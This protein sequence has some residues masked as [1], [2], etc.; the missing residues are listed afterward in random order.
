MTSKRSPRSMPRVA[1]T[2][3][4]A[5]T[6]T[7]KHDTKSQRIVRSTLFFRMNN[8]SEDGESEA[9]QEVSKL[10]ESDEDT[11]R[12]VH[13][14]HRPA[15]ELARLKTRLRHRDLDEVGDQRHGRV[16]PQVVPGP[17][18]SDDVAG[19]RIGSVVRARHERR[20]EGDNGDGRHRQ[21]NHG[22][23]TQS[24]GR[25]RVGRSGGGDRR[26]RQVCHG[27]FRPAGRSLP[28]RGTRAH[29]RASSRRPHRYARGGPGPMDRGRPHRPGSQVEMQEIPCRPGPQAGRRL[30]KRPACRPPTFRALLRL[31]TPW[32]FADRPTLHGRVDALRCSSALARP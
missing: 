20:R 26:G 13:G 11:V 19:E 31:V 32:R 6:E 4:S 22:P 14:E 12:V 1:E 21:R 27:A 9:P 7:A 2:A 18:G 24:E 29:Q 17:L 16:D 15:V 3:T 8:R 25:R 10:L 30:P 5:P 28:R 23:H